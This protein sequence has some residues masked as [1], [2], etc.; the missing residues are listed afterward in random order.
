MMTEAAAENGSKSWRSFL[1]RHWH[2]LAVFVLGA[3]LAAIGAVY[4]FLWFVGD[5]QS[6]GLVPGALAQ[7]TSSN[8]LTFALNVI[9]W[10][11]L[12]IGIPVGIAAVGGWL[13]WRRLP[14]EEREGYHFPSGSRS[15][16]GGGAFSFIFWIA[17]L[18]K[19]FLDGKWN[20]PVSTWTLDY[21]VYSCFWTLVWLAIIFGI[22]AAVG[23]TWWLHHEMKKEP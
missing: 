12:L 16:N 23:L 10:E 1:R 19:I 21:F 8:V 7:W 3:V 20:V 6:S 14:R 13:W 9:F 2:M 4:V 22:P 15:S 17:F 11:L 5:A 18:V